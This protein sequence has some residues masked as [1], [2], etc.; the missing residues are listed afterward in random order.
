MTDEKPPTPADEVPPIEIDGRQF[1]AWMTAVTGGYHR[2]MT[3]A[4]LSAC[5]AAL[6]EDQRKTVLEPYVK[7]WS[8]AHAYERKLHSG[9]LRQWD[10]QVALLN[11]DLAEKELERARAV[12]FSHEQGKRAELAEAKLKDAEAVLARAQADNRSL[13]DRLYAAIK[14]AGEAEADSSFA[15]QALAALRTDE[16]DEKLIDEMMAN[17]AATRE[18]RKMVPAE[19]LELAETKLAEAAAS[20]A[21]SQDY[22][23]FIDQRCA[24]AT[25]LLEA[26]REKI[27]R[28]AS[29][30][31][32]G[33]RRW[34]ETPSANPGDLPALVR[35]VAE[36]LQSVTPAVAGPC[37]DGCAGIEKAVE[38]LD[39]LRQA[40]D[41][42]L[43]VPAATLPKQEAFA[44]IRE[45][46]LEL[47]AAL[48]PAKP[49]DPPTSSPPTPPPS[50]PRES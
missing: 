4:H 50:R 1:E 23:R 2:Y 5:L 11:R 49:A 21:Q 29:D 16:A 22:I 24:D 20:L 6:P 17:R 46:V 31:L 43:E 45:T 8:D 30:L 10:E 15:L 13:N 37:C 42:A 25:L 44:S 39:L 14:D 26:E 27:G 18:E 40:L 34:N 19:A 47:L 33:L 41:V 3:V 36:T 9:T 35:R 32:S 7:Y 48:Q 38:R 12:V 28:A